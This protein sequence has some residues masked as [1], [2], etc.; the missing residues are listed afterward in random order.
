[1]TE[2]K[3]QPAPTRQLVEFKFEVARILLIAEGDRIV[4]ERA[5]PAV[6][7]YG[8]EGLRELADGFAADLAALNEQVASAL[9]EQ[10]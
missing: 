8:V 9:K 3:K 5:F 6:P 1:M 2:P 10:A 7:V 4:G